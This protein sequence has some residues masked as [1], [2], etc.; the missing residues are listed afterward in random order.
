MP[1]KERVFRFKVEIA[2]GGEVAF[3][4]IRP[5]PFCGQNFRLMVLDLDFVKDDIVEIG[6]KALRKA[7][8]RDRIGV[9]HI[10]PSCERMRQINAP[11]TSINPRS[12]IVTV[13]AELFDTDLEG[14]ARG[15]N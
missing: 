1:Q 14:P 13:L 15:S 5:C 11:R 10:A 7:M 9:G 6:M 3:G 12:D 8:L 4:E 2:P